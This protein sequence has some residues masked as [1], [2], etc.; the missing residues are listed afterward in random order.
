MTPEEVRALSDEAL[1]RLVAVE[2]MGAGPWLTRG[3]MWRAN[4]FSTDGN[5]ML[6]LIKKMRADGWDYV[7]QP[8]STGPAGDPDVS[9]HIRWFDVTFQRF[10]DSDDREAFAMHETLPRATAMAAVLA[11]AAQHQEEMNDAE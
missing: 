3:S 5:T 11:R 6:A 10:D 8:S 9:H 7:V 1:D 2:V 4:P